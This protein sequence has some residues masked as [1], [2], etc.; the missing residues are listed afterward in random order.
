MLAVR[1]PGGSGRGSKGVRTAGAAPPRSRLQLTN[2]NFYQ[3]VFIPYS[4]DDQMGWIRFPSLSAVEARKTAPR[5]S[6]RPA[7]GGESDTGHSVILS[8]VGS[9]IFRAFLIRLLRY[10]LPVAVAAS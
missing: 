5:G 7:Q 1:R 4:R 3:K 6:M 10:R 2:Q 8:I 9:S